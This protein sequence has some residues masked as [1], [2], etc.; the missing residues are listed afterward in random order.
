MTVQPTTDVLVAGAGATGL[1]AAIAFARAGRT[2]TL[3]GRVPPPLNGRTVAL[4]EGSLRALDTLGLSE[5]LTRRSA[6]IR[7]FRIVDDTGSVFAP[8][9]AI[10]EAADI[11]LDAFGQNIA[12][13]DLVQALALIAGQ[14]ANLDRREAL[15]TS[16]EFASDH[17]H[18][19]LDD[20]STLVAHLV[21]AADGYKSAARTVAGIETR[22][23][24]YPQV[25][26]TA[27]LRHRR[28]NGA[29]STE[30]HTRSGPF[31]F[32][33]LPSLPDAPHRS[34]LVWL[35]TPR[36]GERRR[37][38]D[39]AALAREI[40]DHSHHWFGPVAI[41]GKIAVF[42]MRTLRAA[43]LVG[44]RL[45]LVGEAA[46]AF[47]PLAAQGLNLGIRDVAD[48]VGAFAGLSLGDRGAVSDALQGFEVSRRADIDLRTRS[49][50]L[51]NRSLLLPLLP[52]D[53]LRGAA[54]AAVTAVAPLRRAVL[55]EGIMP[56]LAPALPR[57]RA[58]RP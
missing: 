50:D 14:T 7:S 4:F 33:P 16:Y 45:L 21:I 39:P 36:E 11:G 32:V 51:L 1:L 22:E 54:L 49:V 18:V 31:T 41:E 40:E 26:L 43:R 15:V 8:P 55:A 47:P 38:L 3:V 13:D 23:W 9:P 53:L 28:T 2:V 34:S 58:T 42:P 17:V 35:M 6:A 46:H 10:F 5:A 30:F 44:P 27:L 24:S 52:T 12:N 57:K 19:T 20:G 29:F 56:A 48:V 37:L 25:A